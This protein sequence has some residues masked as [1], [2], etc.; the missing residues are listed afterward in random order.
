LDNSVSSVY[1]IGPYFMTLKLN[2]KSWEEKN[3]NKWFS[4]K[5]I[6]A[7]LMKNIFEHPPYY[8]TKRRD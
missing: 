3:K 8:S 7:W 4:V 5:I 6:T 2:K 1:E